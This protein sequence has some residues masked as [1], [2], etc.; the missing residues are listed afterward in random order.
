MLS[1]QINTTSPLSLAT[2]KR[3]KVSDGTIEALKWLA[4][5]I[6]T[7]DHINKYIFDQKLAAI[8]ELGRLA[9]PLFSFV[10]AYNL[11]RPD[12]L[13]R[14]LYGRTMKRLALFGG[15]ATPFFLA[16]GHVLYG[17][18]PLNI[19]FMLLVATGTI[20]LLQRGGMAFFASA[21]ILFIVGGAVV[22]FWWFALIFCIAAWWYCKSPT[23]PALVLWLAAAALLY[24]VNRNF[25]VLAAMPIILAAPHIELRV[26]RVRYAFYAYYP[27]H[28]AVLLAISFFNQ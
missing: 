13:Q 5:V 21:V 22:E 27:A 12:A 4:L 3:M 25:W 11:A 6:M 10:L 26:P 2:T 17:W 14:G 1:N 23:K 9:L 8:F 16:L 20:Y 18:W 24:V 15:M 28:L 19:M 7:L